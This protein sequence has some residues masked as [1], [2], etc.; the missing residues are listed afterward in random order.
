MRRVF[1]VLVLG[2]LFAGCGGGSEGEGSAPGVTPAPPPSSTVEQTSPTTQPRSDEE[3]ILAAYQ[4]YWD[5]WLAANDPPNPDHPG[6]ARYYTGEALERARDSIQQNRIAGVLLRLPPGSVYRHEAV[7]T[8]IG[9]GRAAIRDC[10]VDDGLVL[11][12]QDGAVLNNAVVTTHAEATLLHVDG[13]W[14]VDDVVVDA[15]WEGVAGCAM[16]SGS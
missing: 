4:G 16:S 11:S 13:L 7:V 8:E 2:V 15:R 5:T 12:V 14:K 6:L 1:G 10:A 3:A 9:E